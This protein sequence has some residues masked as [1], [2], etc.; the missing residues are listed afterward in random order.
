MSLITQDQVLSADIV[1]I[2]SDKQKLSLAS[3]LREGLL[4]EDEEKRSF[5]T[6]LLWDAQGLKLFEKITYVDEYYLT[7][8][9]IEILQDFSHGIA[10]AIQPGSI[11]LELGSGLVFDLLLVDIQ[12]QFITD[13]PQLPSKGKD[14][15]ASA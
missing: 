6:L 2:R 9:E 1:D 4:Q 11:F 8:S 7:N 13:N 12:E 3:E 10:E 14:P 5:P 15:P